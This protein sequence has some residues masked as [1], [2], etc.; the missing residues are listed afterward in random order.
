MTAASSA[1]PVS[2][3]ERT[4]TLE[5]PESVALMV[6]AALET[7]TRLCLGQFDEIVDLART[8]DLRRRDGGTPDYE[9][10]ERARGFITAAKAELTGMASNE[11][12]GIFSPNVGKAAKVAWAV[13]KSLSHRTSW[14]RNPEGGLGVN[15]DEPFDMEAAPGVKVFSDAGPRAADLPKGYSIQEAP[16]GAY[17]VLQAPTGDETLPL[18]V[19]ESASEQTAIRKALN[20]AADGRGRSTSF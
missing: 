12:H 15:F 2:A 6:Q 11:S 19:A 5:M 4:V 16:G 18:L 7:Y 9:A 1:P 17:R 3:V 20:F 13:K 14:D 10:V 8:G